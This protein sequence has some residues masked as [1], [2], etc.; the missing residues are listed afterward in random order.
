MG[1]CQSLG[2]LREAPSATIALLLF[3]TAHGLIAIEVNGELYPEKG[4]TGVAPEEPSWIVQ[5]HHLGI[6][7]G[8]IDKLAEA[9]SGIVQAA[10]KNQ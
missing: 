8:I 9:L 2:E 5:R 1:E 3:A 10:T 4:L 7:A 6:K